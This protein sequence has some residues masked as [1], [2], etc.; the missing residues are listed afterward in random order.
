MED[1]IFYQSWAVFIINEVSDE[2][3]SKRSME[4]E[5]LL[6]VERL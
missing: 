5:L 1:L 4:I 3:L 2:I 6:S